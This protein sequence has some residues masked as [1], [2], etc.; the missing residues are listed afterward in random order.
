MITAPRV[1]KGSIG[2]VFTPAAS[3]AVMNLAH[4]FKRMLFH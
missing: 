3:I 4:G 1:L 2:T